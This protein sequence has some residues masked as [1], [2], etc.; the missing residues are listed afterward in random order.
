M[1]SPLTISGDRQ[2][3]DTRSITLYALGRRKFGLQSFDKLVLVSRADCAPMD[4]VLISREKFK[5][6]E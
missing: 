5:T 3:S 2:L 4:F 6:S 1:G